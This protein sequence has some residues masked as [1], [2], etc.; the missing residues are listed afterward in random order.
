VV[1]LD[2]AVDSAALSHEDDPWHPQQCEQQQHT[3]LQGILH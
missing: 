3:R 2:A 1:A